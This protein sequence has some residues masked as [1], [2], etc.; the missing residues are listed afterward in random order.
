MAINNFI[1]FLKLPL[2]GQVIMFWEEN[3][4]AQSWKLCSW[5]V[6]FKF[7]TAQDCM[8]LNVTLFSILPQTR[9]WFSMFR[10]LLISLFQSERQT[11]RLVPH[12]GDLFFTSYKFDFQ[13]TC[14]YHTSWW[15]IIVEGNAD[16]TIS[17]LLLL[18]ISPL[19]PRYW[20]FLSAILDFVCLSVSSHWLGHS[21]LKPR[22]SP[23]TPRC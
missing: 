7:Y 3:E 14:S 10:G 18:S 9:Y 16:L 15:E 1:P 19:L 11:E 2:I 21:L 5:R 4:E 20:Q 23:K 17:W 22:S 6:F 13:V 12:A 8:K